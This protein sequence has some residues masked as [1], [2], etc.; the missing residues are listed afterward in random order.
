MDNIESHIEKDKQ[1]LQDPTISPQMRRHTAD[2]LQSLERYREAHPDDD[3][4]PTPLELYCNENP[5]E[6]ECRIYEN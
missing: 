3:H 6:P 1:I 5:N 2:E 4:D